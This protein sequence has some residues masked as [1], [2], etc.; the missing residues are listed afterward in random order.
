MCDTGLHYCDDEIGEGETPNRETQ[1]CQATYRQIEENTVPVPVILSCFNGN[2]APD[3]GNGTCVLERL[4]NMDDLFHCLC[5]GN[6]CNAA[7]NINFSLV[8]DFNTTPITTPP[9]PTTPTGRWRCVCVC[10]CVVYGCVCMH[11]CMCFF[12]CVCVCV[13]ACVTITQ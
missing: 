6:L 8:P 10:V 11:V 5:I 1:R 3:F 9:T 7:Q 2:D 4:S 13:C 12:M